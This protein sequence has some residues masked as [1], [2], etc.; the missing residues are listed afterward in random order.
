MEPNIERE[1][2]IDKLIKLA[3]AEIKMRKVMRPIP[4]RPT[5]IS[6]I[7]KGILEGKRIRGHFY[8]YESSLTKFIAESLHQEALI[9]AKRPKRI[10]KLKLNPWQSR[11]AFGHQHKQ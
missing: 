8:L 1:S 3:E 9:P 7:K 4:S 6:Y 11:I 2:R 5:L 10:K